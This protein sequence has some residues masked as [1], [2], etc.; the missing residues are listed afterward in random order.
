MAVICLDTQIL[1]WGIVKKA[2]RGAEHLVEPAG[3]FLKWLENQA[4]DIIIPTIVLG[5]MLI[6]IP[7]DEQGSVLAQFKRDWMIVDYDSQA[8]LQYA[9]MRRDHIAQKRFKDLRRLH[10]DTTKKEL[11][12]DATI[13]ATAIAHGADKIYSHNEDFLALAQGFI[14]A[15]NFINVPFQLGLPDNDQN[16][17]P[18][19]D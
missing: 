11:V 3:Q 4:H 10:P 13:I 16:N 5:E 8:A 6:P 1:Y 7:D 15:E 2:T 14:P 12:A 17:D 9:K 18:D 19:P